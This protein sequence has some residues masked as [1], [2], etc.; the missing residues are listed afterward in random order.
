M[1]N[2]NSIDSVS[3]ES[4]VKNSPKRKLTPEEIQSQANQNKTVRFRI[5]KKEKD[6]TNQ[7]RLEELQSA[8]SKV[9]REIEQSW[10]IDPEVRQERWDITVELSEEEDFY[11]SSYGVRTRIKFIDYD[12][13]SIIWWRWNDLKVNIDVM[14][15]MEQIIKIINLINM[16]MKTSARKDEVFYDQ[17]ETKSIYMKGILIDTTLVSRFTIKNLPIDPV[18]LTNYINERKYA[19]KIE[20]E[21]REAKK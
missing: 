4:E 16:V 5:E 15:W 17:R 21:R 20:R 14:Q 8:A 12:T 3:S 1:S 10:S 18:H 19:I 9:Q 2:P 6:E 13:I 7:E 11:V